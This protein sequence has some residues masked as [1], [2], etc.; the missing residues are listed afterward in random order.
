[1]DGAPCRQGVSRFITVDLT[2]GGYAEIL[3]C[4]EHYEVALGERLAPEEVIDLS[5]SDLDSEE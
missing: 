5:P 4:V 2:G 1:M 3:M